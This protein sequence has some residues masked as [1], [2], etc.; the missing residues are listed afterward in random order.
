MSPGAEMHAECISH[1]VNSPYRRRVHTSRIAGD[2]YPGQ[3]GKIRKGH[4][5]QCLFLRHRRMACQAAGICRCF[6]KRNCCSQ[7]HRKRGN[8]RR[9]KPLAEILPCRKKP[10]IPEDV[11]LC[12]A[13]SCDGIDASFMHKP[14]I[15]AQAERFEQPALL[16]KNSRQPHTPGFSRR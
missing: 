4:F 3:V 6:Q 14:G 16:Q 7:S 5:L 10:R 1:L 12:G 15:H 11:Y 9:T 13:K 8:I 2:R